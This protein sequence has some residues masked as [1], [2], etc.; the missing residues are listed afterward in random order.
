M[1][2]GI[3]EKQKPKK[4]LSISEILQLGVVSE[5]EDSPTKTTVISEWLWTYSR[6]DVPRLTMGY[7]PIKVDKKQ[8]T[9]TTV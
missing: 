3:V 9:W 7:I 5:W 2:Q 6:A 8:K 1:T 4:Q